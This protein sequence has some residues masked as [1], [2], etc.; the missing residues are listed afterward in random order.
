MPGEDLSILLVDDDDED[1]L[2]VCDLITRREPRWNVY[3][4]KSLTDALA[5][6]AEQEY[7]AML[8]DYRLGGFDT[9]T[10]LLRQLR[11]RGNHTPAVFLTAYG[12][13]EIAVMAMKAGAADYLPKS[14]LSGL[15]LVAAIRY[16]LALRHNPRLACGPLVPAL[17]HTSA[18][19]GQN[20]GVIKPWHV[21]R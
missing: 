11:A 15:G 17:E 20:P 5:R 12:D 7:D 14:R 13:E 4:A 19:V 2:I 16:A 10:D 21:S 18:A 1:A 6:C 3:R 8:L 9:G